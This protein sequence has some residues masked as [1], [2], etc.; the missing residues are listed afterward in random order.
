MHKTETFDGNAQG[1]W[2]VLP[3]GG[4]T[5]KALALTQ[6]GSNLYAFHTG[7]GGE[8]FISR[9]DGNNWSAWS[10]VPTTGRTNERIAATW[11]ESNLF[12]K[13]TGT[14]LST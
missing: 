9:F 6:F 2:N 13:G 3:I 5:K 7:L 10:E 11:Y 12:V 8:I 1:S 14:V 4:Q